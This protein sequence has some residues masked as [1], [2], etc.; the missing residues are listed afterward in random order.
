MKEI[1]LDSSLTVTQLKANEF[2]PKYFF[3]DSKGFEPVTNNL[4]NEIIHRN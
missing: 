1:I 4:A 2:N 3:N